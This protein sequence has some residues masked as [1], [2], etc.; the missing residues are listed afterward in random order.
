MGRSRG[1]PCWKG[2]RPIPRNADINADKFQGDAD[3]QFR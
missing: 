1:K 2:H 3:G